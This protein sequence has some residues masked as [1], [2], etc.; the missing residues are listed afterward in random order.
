MGVWAIV[1]SPTGRE[2]ITRWPHAIAFTA[3]LAYWAFLWPSA[4]GLVIALAS[5]WLA[6]CDLAGQVAPSH[7]KEARSYAPGNRRDVDGPAA[8]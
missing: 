1:R 2:W 6:H 5:L 7:S 8:F 3:G 4:L